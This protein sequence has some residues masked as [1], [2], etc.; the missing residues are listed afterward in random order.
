MVLVKKKDGSVR[1][2]IDYRALNAVTVKDVYPLPRVDETLQALHGATRFT[3]LDLHA[4]YWQLGVAEEDKPKTAFTT[5]RGLF[6]FCR[7]P[8]G[9]CNALSTFQRLINCVLRGLTWVCCLVYLDD[10]IIFTSGSVAKHVV[11]LAVELERLAE[12]GLSLKATKCSFAA[13][14][15][16]Y[17]GHDLTPEGIK[18]TSRLV[19]A[20][21]D[22]PTPRNDV[23]V[24]RFVALAGYYRRFMPDFGSRM[25][26]LTSLLRKTSVWRWGQEQ[27][28]AFLWAKAKLSVKPVLIYPD[29][30]L[31]FKLTTDASKTGL[32]A[33]LSQ[34]QGQGDQPV[35]FASKV[36]SP[37]VAKYSISELECLAV[38]WA[39]KQFRPHIYGRKFTIVT[40][41][42]ALRW[43]MT[44]KEPAGRLHRWALTLQEYD[45]EIQYRPGRENH[46]ADALSR[47]PAA[48]AADDKAAEGSNEADDPDIEMDTEP[49][50]HQPK[51][52]AAADVL[53]T[54]AAE[55]MDVAAAKLPS[56]E[57]ADAAG[58]AAADAKDAVADAEAEPKAVVVTVTREQIAADVAKWGISSQATGPQHD[59][60]A[61]AVEAEIDRVAV[62]VVQAAAAW[63][64]EAAEMGIVQFTDAGI[65]REQERSVMVQTLK[66][67]G[68]YRGQPIVVDEDGLVNIVLASGDKRVI[69]PVVYCALAF[70]EA[71]DSIWAGHLRIPKTYERLKR[72]YWWPHMLEAVYSWVAACQDCGSRKARP[73]A[74][75][76][77]LRSVRTG[78]VCDRWAIDVAGPLPVTENGNRYVIAAV[79][80]TTRYA[81]AEAVAEHTA[82]AIARFLMQRVVLV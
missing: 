69:L 28:E 7:M 1:F 82:K 47:G 16:E 53:R 21:I 62:N 75:V 65:K 48:E 10:V 60:A 38:V 55:A 29:Y 19:K 40:D 61:A 39:V 17:L 37:T 36:N 35:A 23:E 46:V 45:F 78:D 43:L 76:P 64:V 72:M 13:T 57:A 70:K 54:V 34:D 6:Q 9:L 80:Y 77:P 52:I 27:D 33:V 58:V 30:T 79:E 5:R 14:S 63:R 44:A 73:A 4:G 8:F 74:V 15:M 32:G 56:A 51:E 26:P 67:K 24:R 71:H 12:A 81:V 20:I 42:V 41:H 66:Q 31:P 25:A 49:P 50:Q 2:C 22:F 11:E 18:P 68:T 59:A 3:S